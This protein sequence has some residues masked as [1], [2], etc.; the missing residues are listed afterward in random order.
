MQGFWSWILPFR[1]H[2]FT[3]LADWH[4]QHDLSISRPIAAVTSL[5]SWLLSP[6][7]R[8]PPVVPHYPI[9]SCNGAPWVLSERAVDKPRR[10]TCEMRFLQSTQRSILLRLPPYAPTTTHLLCRMPA[11]SSTSHHASEHLAALAESPGTIAA[12]ILLA[13]LHAGPVSLRAQL[14]QV[15]NMSDADLCEIEG[16]LAAAL[17]KSRAWRGPGAML[18]PEH[19]PVSVQLWK[20]ELPFRA[21]HS[22]WLATQPA[23]RRARPERRLRLDRRPASPGVGPYCTV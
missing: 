13:S 18:V 16:V 12:E 23:F 17:D 22:C 19:L 8:S 1:L 5:A 6:E 2:L 11:S 14:Q 20:I 4:R 15:C 10:W 3:L 7:F 21:C 9:Q